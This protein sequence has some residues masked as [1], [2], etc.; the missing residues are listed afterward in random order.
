MAPLLPQILWAQRKDR[1]LITVDL[2]DAKQPDIKLENKD[3]AGVV[4]FASQARSHA[5]GMDLH[6]YAITL[7]LFGEINVEESQ[8][9][10]TD[11]RVLVLAAKKADDTEHWPRLLKSKDKKSNIKVDWS[12]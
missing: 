6:E 2:Q 9:S 7:E 3:G 4:N 8:T 12:K 5:T 1:I 10:V 11:R